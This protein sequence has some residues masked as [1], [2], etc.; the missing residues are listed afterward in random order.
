MRGTPTR[1]HTRPPAFVVEVVGLPGTGKTTTVAELLASRNGELA[2]VAPGGWRNGRMLARAALIA[3]IPFLSQAPRIGRRRLDKFALMV[4]LNALAAVVERDRHAG[5]SVL[6][7]D[8]GPVYM[9]G[10][11]QRVLSSPADLNA[12]AFQRFWQASVAAWSRALDL[13]VYLDASDDVLYERIRARDKRHR[14]KELSRGE[15]D[16]RFQRWRESR[17]RI[18]EH[19]EVGRDGPQWTHVDTGATSID[20]VRLQILDRIGALQGQEKRPW[21]R[22]P[23]AR[24]VVDETLPR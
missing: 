15:A 9:L 7:L 13:V 18:L 14:V 11:L 12:P 10:I 16:A 23:E 1:T 21:A 6:L 17:D 5:P 2:R 19:L 20:D 8:Q 22:Y 24:P 3:A 4:Q